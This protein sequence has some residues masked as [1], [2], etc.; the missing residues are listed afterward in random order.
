MRF[1]K[2]LGSFRKPISRLL[3][4]IMKKE[5]S[6][7]AEQQANEARKWVGSEE[8]KKSLTE[9]VKRDISSVTEFSKAIR[10]DRKS[11]SDLFTV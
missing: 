10:I 5:N 11:L 8:G 6:H 1:P 3:G 7:S 9:S 2:I 4:T